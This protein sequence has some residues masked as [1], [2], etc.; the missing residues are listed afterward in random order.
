MGF[1]N[2]V[3]L[4]DETVVSTKSNCFIHIFFINNYTLVIIGCHLRWLLSLLYKILIKTK[5]FIKSEKVGIKNT[6]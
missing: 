3:L 6:F 1:E 4:N 5:A 2:E